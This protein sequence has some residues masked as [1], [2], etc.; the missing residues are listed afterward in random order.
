MDSGPVANWSAGA[1]LSAVLASDAALQPYLANMAATAYLNPRTTPIPLQLPDWNNWLPKIWP[2]DAYGAT[3]T[4]G[5]AMANYQLARTQLAPGTPAA[6]KSS[7]LNAFNNWIV[8]TQALIASLKTASSPNWMAVTSVQQWQLVKQWE[9]NQDFGLEAMASAVFPKPNNRAWYGEAA[10]QMEPVSPK[11]SP[12]FMNGL[13]STWEYMDNA[14]NFLQFILNDGQGAQSA[15]SPIDYAYFEGDVKD[16]SAAAGVAGASMEL[17]V[18]TK[19]LQENTLIGTG[20]QGGYLK[21][22]QPQ[23]TSPYPLA[24]QGFATNWVGYTAAA[25]TALTAQFALAWVNQVSSYTPAQFYAGKDGNGRAFA[26][27]TENCANLTTDPLNV[28]GG[29]VWRNLPRLR[30][31]GVPA[32]TMTKIYAFVGKLFPGTNWAPNI[33]ATCNATFSACSS[34][35]K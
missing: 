29:Q 1:G 16:L 18:L 31:V 2:G 13:L 35:A 30:A 28:F 20:P 26:S 23:P 34:D 24:N 8:T 14:W 7:T 4:A 33:A 19:A 6:Y 3:F 17:Y 11:T 15:S 27:A 12:Q 32:S 9:L 5:P 10:F 21:G 25:Q 22:F